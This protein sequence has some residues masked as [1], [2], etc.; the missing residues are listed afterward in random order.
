MGPNSSMT[1]A[2]TLRQRA[3]RVLAGAGTAELAER[4]SDWPDPPVAEFLRGPEAGHVMVQARIGGGGDRF[5]LGEATVCR[6]TVVLRGGCLTADAVG[7]SYVLGS[8]PDHAGLAAV[9][10]ALLND[11][12]QRDLVLHHVIEPLEREQAERD[13]YVHTEARS[14][15]V[16]FLTVAREH[17]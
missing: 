10:D 14:T 9:F 17:R 12:G 3:A 5:N 15:V 4:W 11:T 7:T 1:E 6:A 2:V 8:D 13:A 16:N